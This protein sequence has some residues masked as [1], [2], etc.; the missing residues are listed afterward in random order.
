MLFM[1]E[2]GIVKGQSDNL[3]KIALYEKNAIASYL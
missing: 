1:M 3:A 2:L